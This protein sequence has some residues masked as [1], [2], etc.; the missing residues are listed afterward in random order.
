MAVKRKTSHL[1]PSRKLSGKTVYG[2][3]GKK[4]GSIKHV[5]VDEK[6][7]EIAHAVLGIGG[8]FGIGNARYMVPWNVLRYDADLGAYSSDISENRLKGRPKHGVETIFDWNARYAT[9]H[10][11][12]NEVVVHPG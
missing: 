2:A 5:M 6:K 7:G 12:N 8:L 10:P 4:I 11:Y 9:L 3:E 1:R